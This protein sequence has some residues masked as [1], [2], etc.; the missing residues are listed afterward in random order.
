MLSEIG[1]SKKSPISE[2]IN[3]KEINFGDILGEYKIEEESDIHKVYTN[4]IKFNNE[5][6]KTILSEHPILLG[7][8]NE[9]KKVLFEKSQVKYFI[10]SKRVVDEHFNEFYSYNENDSKDVYDYISSHIED[11]VEEAINIRNKYPK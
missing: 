4:D 2:T 11:W 7:N 9:N 1:F 3:F 8:M 6:Y 5:V 10:Q